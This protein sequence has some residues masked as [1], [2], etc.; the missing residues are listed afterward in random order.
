MMMMTAN[1]YTAPN[2]HGKAKLM[3]YIILLYVLYVCLTVCLSVY[4]H[5]CMHI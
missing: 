1:L 5:E 4:I 3:E 2:I